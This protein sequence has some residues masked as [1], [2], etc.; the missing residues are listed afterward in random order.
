MNYW[1]MQLHPADPQRA[2]FHATQSFVCRIHDFEQ[3][4]GDLMRAKR[5]NLPAKPCGY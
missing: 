4:K 3:D 1:R 2:G 5:K